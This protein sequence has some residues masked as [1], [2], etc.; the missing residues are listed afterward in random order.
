MARIVYHIAEGD[1]VEWHS[2]NRD[3]R[4]T[5]VRLTPR[6]ALVA[7]DGGG[8]VLLTTPEA[9]EHIRERLES[10]NKSNTK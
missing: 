6:G 7:V 3:L 1:R 8:Q 2:L 4:G 9:R 5:V 10:S